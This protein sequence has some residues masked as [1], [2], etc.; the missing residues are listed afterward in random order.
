MKYDMIIFDLDGTLWETEKISYKT[1]NAV[2]KKGTKVTCK[3]IIE[4]NGNIWIKIPS[5]YV[6]GIYEGNIYIK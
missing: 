5:G 1:A 3:D 6:A 4:E 2:L